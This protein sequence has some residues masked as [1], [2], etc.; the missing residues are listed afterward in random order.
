MLRSPIVF[1]TSKFIE[2]KKWF[3]SINTFYF[4]FMTFFILL[5]NICPQ[6]F[7]IGFFSVQFSVLVNTNSLQ[8]VYQF[9]KCSDFFSKISSFYVS[10]CLLILYL[11]SARYSIQK[12]RSRDNYSALFVFW[13]TLDL[14]L[15][16]CIVFPIIFNNK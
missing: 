10:M 9:S 11:C 12:I 1:W 14:I 2:K 8:N 16:L 6:S 4:H 5:P 13:L 7:I 15:W 3:N